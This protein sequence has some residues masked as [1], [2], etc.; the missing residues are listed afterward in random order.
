[1]SD[2]VLECGAELVV[3]ADRDGTAHGLHRAEQAGLEPDD[4]RA[5]RVQRGRR[6]AARRR[7]RAG[8][9]RRRRLAPDPRPRWST[10]AAPTC[11]ARS[12]PGCASGDRFVDASAVSAVYRRPARTWPLWLLALLLLA[13]VVAT[14]VLAPDAT[15]VGEN[16]D[17]VVERVQDV[18][19]RRDS[20]C[21]APDD[22]SAPPAAGRRRGRAGARARPRARRRPGGRPLGREPRR[23]RGPAGRPGRPAAGPGRR[24]RAAGPAPT[25]AWSPPSAA[26]SPTARL[27]GHSVLLVAYAGRDRR[28]GPPD[29]GRPARRRRQPHRRA[30]ADLDVRRPGQGHRPAGGPGAAAGAAERRVRATARAPIERVGTVLAR[31]TVAAEPGSRDRPGRRRADRRPR[32]ARRGAPRRRPRPAGRA[33]RRRLRRAGQEAGRAGRHRACSRA[34]DAAAAPAPS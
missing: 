18:V 12:S 9:D 10:P 21:V 8:A 29:P 13:G 27:E 32:R 22:R 15:P 14:V 26:G 23:P 7:P 1:M 24:P 19:A 5:V 33:G 2:D 34:L 25:P 11:R 3:R 30:D 20:G 4:L 28:A 6:A 16:R 17:Q 31:S